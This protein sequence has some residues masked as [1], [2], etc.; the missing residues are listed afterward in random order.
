MIAQHGLIFSGN[1][2]ALRLYIKGSVDEDAVLC[3]KN[4]TYT[5]RQVNLSNSLLLASH[6][7]DGD[8][9]VYNIKDTQFSTIE[10]LPCLPRLEKL[11]TLLTPT[12]YTGPENEANVQTKV[13]IRP[14]SV[15]ES[16][17]RRG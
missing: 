16:V 1:L 7:Q 15:L 14:L 3:T 8:I 17:Q 9:S 4:K 12:M 5:V 2:L 6:I 10:L 11:D 13:R